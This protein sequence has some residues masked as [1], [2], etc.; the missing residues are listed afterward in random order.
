MTSSDSSQARVADARK[1][2]DSLNQGD[3][4]EWDDVELV[5]RLRVTDEVVARQI[6]F[7][8]LDALL[9]TWHE[10]QA[11]FTGASAS[12]GQFG[13]SSAD[14]PADANGVAGPGA[15]PASRRSGGNGKATVVAD[16]LRALTDW[17]DEARAEGRDLDGVTVDTLRKIAEIGPTQARAFKR[18]G[19]GASK[20]AEQFLDVLNRLPSRSSEADVKPVPDVGPERSD[21]AEGAPQA[22]NS[23]GREIEK[24][25]EPTQPRRTGAVSTTGFADFDYAQPAGPKPS[26]H[27]VDFAARDDESLEMRWPAPPNDGKVRIFRVV[28]NNAYAPIHS[29]LL[30]DVIVATFD[31]H[32]V[33]TRDFGSPVRHVA[34][35]VNEGQTEADARMAQPSLYASGGCVLPVRHC[36][37][38]EDEGSIIGQWEAIDGVIRI[39]VLRV[40]LDQAEQHQHYNHQYRLSPE[41]V[42][43]GGFT[44]D[45]ATPGEEYEYRVYAVASVSGE[46]EELSPYVARRVKLQA[47]VQSV[48]DLAVSHRQGSEN[49][50]DL[51]WTM[52][53]LG[54]VEIYRSESPPAPGIDQV[55]L[56]R[57][58]LVRQG[59][60]AE[61]RLARAL[62]REG[63]TGAMNDVP[64]PKGWSRAY[65]TPVTVVNDEQIRVGKT[66]ILTRSNAVSH[67]RLIERVDEQFLTFAWPEGVSMVK[68]YQGPKG[69]ELINPE[70]QHAIAELSEEEYAKYGGAHLPHA[71]PPDGCAVHV[72]GTSYTRGRAV[73]SQPETIQYEGLARLR[74]DLI[75]LTQGGRFKRRP[76][77]SLRKVVVQCD[78]SPENV[79]LVLVHNPHRMPLY[80][81]DGQ[82]LHRRVLSFAPHATQL[83]AEQIDLAGMTGFVRLFVDVPPHM[84]HLIAVLDPAVAHLRCG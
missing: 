47:V 16:R 73:L 32:A 66:Q 9:S 40:P 31:S 59:L 80:T 79:P 64:W 76:D 77:T 78:T 26:P 58:T 36:E 50:Y 46:D 3:A 82:V 28:T 54:S 72:V 21:A 18:F 27:K 39:D 69:G 25:A 37:V 52:P 63:D 70:S 71:L 12:S 4:P 68:I 81:R 65:F 57:A 34:I 11:V 62:E 20:N 19:S 38:R 14:L 44:D 84:E 1:W 43:R 7:G 48:S 83:V 41:V 17:Y 74:Y 49:T 23:N 61:L 2:Y 30:G 22:A 67:V 6:L 75:P 24:P 35:W 45:E 53:P 5:A 42:G 56:D 60:T 8:K 33:D 13:Q 15:A 10:L 55:V 51:R 29:P